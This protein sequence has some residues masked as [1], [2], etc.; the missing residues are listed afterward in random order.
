MRH[1]TCFRRHLAARHAGAAPHSA[2][3]ELGVVRRCSRFPKP[4]IQT[5][6]LMRSY[7]P[8]LLAVAVFAASAFGGEAV[9]PLKRSQ[10]TT[11][12]ALN[13]K[14]AA[15]LAASLANADSQQ[16]FGVAPFSA[17][18]ATPQLI[19]GQWHWQATAGYGKTDLQASVSFSQSGSDPT[20][21]VRQL[22]LER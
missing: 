21:S 15:R 22:V 13:A 17:S 16:R 9:R 12:S 8:S 7:L 14:T 19:Q 20:V 3:A 11:K 5:L 10:P 2:V 18:R 1:G 6:I 4:I